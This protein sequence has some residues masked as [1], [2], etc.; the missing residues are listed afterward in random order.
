MT[1]RVAKYFYGMDMGL[2]Y[3]PSNPEHISRP[4][5]VFTDLTG[6][7]RISGSFSVILPKVEAVNLLKLFL[8]L[9]HVQNASVSET[10]EYRKSYYRESQSPSNL[11]TVSEAIVCFRG[12]REDPRWL[13]EEKRLFFL[14]S[15]YFS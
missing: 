10:E 14:P 12:Q 4:H 7:K 8:I 6:H 3:D 11:N 1:T 5:S 15:L 2:S 13:D 9:I